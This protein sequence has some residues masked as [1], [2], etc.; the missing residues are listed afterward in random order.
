V[1]QLWG[2]YAELS[3][4]LAGG[5]RLLGEDPVL[6]LYEGTMR[7][8]FAGP[9]VQRFF[10][11]RRRAEARERPTATTRLPQSAS[12]NSPTEVVTLPVAS[13]SAGESRT[14]AERAFRRA[15]TIDSS[16]AEARIRLA[17]VLGDAGRHD[18]AAAEL[19]QVPASGLPAVLDYYASLLT[20][21]EARL[22]G[23]VQAARAAFERAAALYPNA[24][25]PK[26][27]LSEL[28]MA[29]RNE[30][31]SLSYLIRSDAARRV[32]ANEPWWWLDRVHDPSAGTLLDDLRQ[33]APR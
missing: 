16:L 17:Q 3:A 4:H 29:Q 26:F 31:D 25:A 11:E 12:G 23:Q 32:D 22:R 21:R 13:P 5:R 9:R 7:Q 33:V 27:G 1:L 6:L 10:D 2:E 14:Q 24:S 28:A 30:S 18:A 15:L 19:K 20:G 8:A